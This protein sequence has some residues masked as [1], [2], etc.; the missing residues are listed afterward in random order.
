MRRFWK[1]FLSLIGWTALMALMFIAAV[2][3]WAWVNPKDAYGFVERRFLP[4]DLRVTWDEL[5][6]SAQHL[7]GLDFQVDVGFTGLLIRKDSP[8]LELP[9]HHARLK[10]SVFPLQ[11]RATAHE[12]AVSAGHLKITPPQR[13]RDG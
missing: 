13:R 7:G 12:L 1:L 5:H 6:F 8:S 10:A 11:R 3:S 4:A 2:F 9:F